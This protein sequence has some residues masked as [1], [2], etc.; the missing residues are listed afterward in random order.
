MA[1][2][3]KHCILQTRACGSFYFLS[4]VVL[5]R[6]VCVPTCHLLYKRLFKL[7]PV[8]MQCGP[9]KNC[10]CSHFLSDVY[11]SVQATSYL[12]CIPLFRLPPVTEHY[13]PLKGHLIFSLSLFLFLL[14]HSTLHFCSHFMTL[15]KEAAHLSGTLVST[16]RIIWSFK[17][18]DHNSKRPQGQ[19]QHSAEKNVA[20]ERQEVTGGC[21]KPHKRSAITLIYRQLL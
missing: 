14:V 20:H 12:T 10:C 19:R 7:P 8:T 18:E 15:K 21:R 3:E 5:E 16:Y 1:A 9:E 2:L 4:T 6:V 17:A 11:S 13:L